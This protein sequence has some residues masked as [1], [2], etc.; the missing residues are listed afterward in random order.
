MP[1][2]AV[3]LGQRASFGEYTRFAAYYCGG[4]GV[5]EKRQSCATFSFVVTMRSRFGVTVAVAKVN[6]YCGS[7]AG[8]V[9]AAFSPLKL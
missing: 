2:R 5:Q 1:T 8:A 3:S 4:S 6:P 9:S 7:G